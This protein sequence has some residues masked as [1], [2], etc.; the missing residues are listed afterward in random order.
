MVAAVDDHGGGCGDDHDNCGG[1]GH[2]SDGGYGDDK[3]EIF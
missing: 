1:N 3:F 2:V